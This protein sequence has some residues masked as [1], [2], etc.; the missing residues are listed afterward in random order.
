MTKSG[1]DF[2]PFYNEVGEHFETIFVPNATKVTNT[3]HQVLLT[4]GM[5]F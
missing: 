3:R 5:R 2:Y 4:L 1:E